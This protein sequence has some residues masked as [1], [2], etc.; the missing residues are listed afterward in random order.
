MAWIQCWRTEITIQSLLIG[1]VDSLLHL[2]LQSLYT[3]G[4]GEVDSARGKKKKKKP[5]VLAVIMLQKKKDSSSK[6]CWFVPSNLNY[7]ETNL[8]S[9]EQKHGIQ[10]KPEGCNDK[11]LYPRT[12][13]SSYDTMINK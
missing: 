6:V 5:Q 4:V 8:Q 1:E 7:Y 10:H 11:D 9:L 13:M 12:K 2:L 3:G